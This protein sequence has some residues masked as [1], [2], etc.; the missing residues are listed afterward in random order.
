MKNV[1]IQ[2]FVE[3][4]DEKKLINTLKKQLGVVQPGKVQNLNVIQS[5]IP[6][7]VLRTLKKGTMVV[8]VFDTDT[9]NADILNDNIRLLKSC[10]FISKVITVPQVKNLEDELVRSCDIRNITELLNSRSKK[11]YKS[12][13]IR[14]TNLDSKLK[15][16]KFDINQFWSKQPEH[17]Y[18]H[19]TNDASQIK[20]YAK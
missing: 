3:G 9:G 4:E 19:I 20:I 7:N 15:E 17:P 1:N 10:S 2:Y 11:D 14:I 6:M 16:H 8:L 5:R 12:D 18:Q 13:L